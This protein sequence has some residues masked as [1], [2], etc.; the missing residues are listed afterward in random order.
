MLLSVEDAGEEDVQGTGTHRACRG[1][2]PVYT[3]SASARFFLSSHHT[4]LRRRSRGRLVSCRLVCVHSASAGARIIQSVI[5]VNKR[6]RGHPRPV[7]SVRR[8]EI[9]RTDRVRGSTF[10]YGNAG[11]I[12]TQ[13]DS[14]WM[15]H[16]T[17]Y[18]KSLVQQKIRTNDETYLYL[19]LSTY[20]VTSIN[21]DGTKSIWNMFV[22]INL[23]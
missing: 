10:R 23:F 22:S 21:I 20:I 16:D 5:F 7:D 2:H 17:M 19:Y 9:R 8:Q 15:S 18:N 4:L 1:V 6:R 13:Y 14:H 11:I 3:T 12:S